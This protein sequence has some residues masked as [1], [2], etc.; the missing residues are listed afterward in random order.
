MHLEMDN[1]VK[2]PL[3]QLKGIQVTNEIYKYNS[4]N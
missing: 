2:S 3:R 1:G 4:K